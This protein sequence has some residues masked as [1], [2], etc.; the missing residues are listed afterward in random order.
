MAA[1]VISIREHVQTEVQ[2]NWLGAEP[3]RDP[4]EIALT[5][6]MWA[7]NQRVRSISAQLCGVS[8]SATDASRGEA[9]DGSS[10]GR[11]SRV[12]VGVALGD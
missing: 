4:R 2:V 12:A 7:S 6:Q 10:R 5:E 3:I 1:K 8:L 9:T 11:V